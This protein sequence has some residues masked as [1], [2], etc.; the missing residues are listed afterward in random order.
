[1]MHV[2]RRVARARN[3]RLRGNPKDASRMSTRR[4][5]DALWSQCIR[6]RRG[7]KAGAD[8][9]GGDR[10]PGATDVPMRMPRISYRYV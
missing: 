2:P 10:Q 4:A 5:G 7:G 1:M 6:I 9:P 3:R 8:P